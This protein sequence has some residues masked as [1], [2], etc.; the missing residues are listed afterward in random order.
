MSPDV[1][2]AEFD[3]PSRKGQSI[4]YSDRRLITIWNHST[5]FAIL[6]ASFEEYHHDFIQQILS[7][8]MNFTH[9]TSTHTNLL[10]GNPTSDLC[11]DL[12][13]R[14]AAL[15]LSFNNPAFDQPILVY[16]GEIDALFDRSK[17]G[18]IVI[19]NKNKKFA[20]TPDSILGETFSKVAPRSENRARSRTPSK[21]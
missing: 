14:S 11:H 15:Q 13:R 8:Q 2:N 12:L 19:Q 9:F 5:A 4:E 21:G 10:P 7:A 6:E 1:Q 20:T 17:C 16:F 3:S 18:A